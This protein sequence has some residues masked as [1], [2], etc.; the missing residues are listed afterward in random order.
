VPARLGTQVHP[1]QLD[2]AVAE[3]AQRHRADDL[4]A[5]LGDPERDIARSWVVEVAVERGIQLEAELGQGVGDERA[6]AL[7][8]P[9]FERD[10]FDYGAAASPTRYSYSER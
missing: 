5:V 6:K 7:R 8:V 4:A 3:I 2:G 10:D 1:L 9:R